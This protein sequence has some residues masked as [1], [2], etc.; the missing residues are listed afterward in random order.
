LILDISYA[1]K[2]PGQIYP[3]QAEVELPE[4]IVLDDPVRFE[5]ISLEGT[6]VGG[7]DSVRLEGVIRA[8][9]HTRC[10]ECLEPAQVALES[11]FD[12]MFV[13]DPDPEDP[14]LYPIDGYR[15]D[16]APMAQEALLLE[17]PMRVLCSE[18]C[19]GICP[20]CGQNRNIAPCTCQEGGERH[21][22]PFSALSE[23]L[24]QDEEV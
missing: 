24:T 9:A 13:R 18:S 10:C 15:I 16:L 7:G 6:F 21:N 4:L 22:N 11:D 5:G 3:F 14:D 2:N 20:V 19:K 17:L 1:L 8:V 23:L 12:V